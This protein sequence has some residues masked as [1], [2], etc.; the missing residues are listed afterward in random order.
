MGAETTVHA[1]STYLK[2]MPSDHLLLKV[3]F[4][5][6]FNSISRDKMLQACFQHASEIY[7]LVHHTFFGNTII[8][9]SEGVQQGDPLDPLLFNLSI[10]ST[11][12]R[13]TA[14]LKLFYLDDVTLGGSIDEILRN[15]RSLEDTA[16]D[17]GLQLLNHNKTEIVCFNSSTLSTLQ[18]VSPDFRWLE[19][20]GACLLGSPIGDLNSIDKVLCSKHAIL[21]TMSERGCL[22]CTHKMLSSY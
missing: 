18:S 10:H 4:T 21:K 8:D 19:P 12:S 22:C 9:S 20:S 7:P 2:N 17:L 13:L 15:L 1:T 16:D 3:D 14:E 5:N 11:L 6:A